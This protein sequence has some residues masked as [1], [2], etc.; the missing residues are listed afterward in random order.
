MIN[1]R[2]TFGVTVLIAFSWD[3][4]GT[5]GSTIFAQ[6][7]A[8]Y[9]WPE[10]R[11]TITPEITPEMVKPHVVKLAD[12]SLEGRCAGYRGEQKAA[13]YIAD[14][15]KKIGL[16]PVVNSTRGRASY[17]QEFTFYPWNP[18]VPFEVLTSRNVVGFIEG[19]DP[20]LKSEVVVVGAHYD[21]QGRVGQADPL[22]LGVEEAKSANDEIWNSA[23][24]NAASVAAILEIARAISSRKIVTKRSILFIA[25]GAEEHGM[26]GSIYYVSHP[27]FP[28]ANHV[29]MINLEKLGHSPDQPF[30]INASASSPAWA[31]VIQ[32]AREQTKTEI[33]PNIPFNVPDSDHYPFNVSGVP[34]V[35]LYVSATPAH[36]A[37][38]T[39]DRIDFRRVAEAARFAMAMLLDLSTR[40]NR[41]E[42]ATSPIPDLGLIASLVKA[43][44]ADAR[45][46]ST[47]QGGLKVTGVIP[48]LPAAISGLQPGDFIIEFANHKFRRDDEV[49]A[50]MAMYREVLE[51]KRGNILPLKIIRGKERLDLT[52]TLRP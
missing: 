26:A 51:G 16:K 19:K 14:E 46:L 15:F 48:A 52:V 30:S 50:L 42:Y 3:F 7:G 41:P 18:V 29:A 40:A 11:G 8:A 24:D 2:T 9:E 34:S 20:I 28:L 38:D 13:S 43:A 1:L 21:G 39:S 12:D 33:K 36:F 32:T 23:N 47:P 31:N 45:G 49:A 37:S 17:I 35:M 25:F 27:V 22:R 5:A 44:E 6:P 4:L 10:Q